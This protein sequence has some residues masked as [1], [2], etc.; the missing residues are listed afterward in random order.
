M[1]VT[2]LLFV[3]LAS[4]QVVL[5]SQYVCETLPPLIY[6]VS[7]GFTPEAE[8]RSVH[9]FTHEVP[10][11]R[12]VAVLSTYQFVP[13]P[14]LSSTEA[15]VTV[16]PPDPPGAKLP[17]NWASRL[18]KVYVPGAKGTPLIDTALNWQF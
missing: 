11:P 3:P 13:L 9:A 1:Y 8:F 10:F 14:P 18:L 7:P 5:L 12:P 15:G 16:M 2:G 4:C 6:T 17:G